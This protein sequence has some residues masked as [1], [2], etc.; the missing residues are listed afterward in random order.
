M[1]GVC[2]LVQCTSRAS[3]SEDYVLRE[4]HFL[5]LRRGKFR[6]EVDSELEY[7]Q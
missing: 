5:R 4:G 1:R 2:D 6:R 3:S 7:E